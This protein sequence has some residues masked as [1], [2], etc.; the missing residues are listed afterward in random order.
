ME[1]LY[2]SYYVPLLCGQYGDSNE[3]QGVDSWR[4]ISLS[5]LIL[6]GIRTHKAVGFT[7]MMEVSLVSKILIYHK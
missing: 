4:A 7:G 6:K 2:L 1:D 3:Q 5:V